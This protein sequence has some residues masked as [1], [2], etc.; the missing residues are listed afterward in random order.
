VLCPPLDFAG[1]IIVL[2]LRKSTGHRPDEQSFRPKQKAHDV[3]RGP[4]CMQAGI[5]DRR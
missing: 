5:A 3:G 4:A 2:E 1:E